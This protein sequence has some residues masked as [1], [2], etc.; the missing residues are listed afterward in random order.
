MDSEN[1]ECGQLG[2][3]CTR[4][5]RHLL[6]AGGMVLQHFAAFTHDQAGIKELRLYTN[7]Y[8]ALDRSEY[9]DQLHGKFGIWLQ[10]PLNCDR[11]VEYHNPHF[12]FYPRDRE[13]RPILT[14]DLWHV[15]G[16]GTARSGRE[17]GCE[18]FLED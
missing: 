11:N 14:D 6:I 1:A 13:G 12:W 17:L 8:G 3:E 5:F 4:V 18:T 7:I 10:H 2:D 9:A 16:E 15:H